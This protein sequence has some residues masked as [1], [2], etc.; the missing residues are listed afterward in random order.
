[1]LLVAE[2]RRWAEKAERSRIRVGLWLG[3]FDVGKAEAMNVLVFNCGS[4]SLKYRLIEMPSERQLAAGEAQRVGPPTALP[5]RVIHKVGGKEK[6]VEVPMPTH[7]DA[8]EQVMA[9]LLETPELKPD[10]VGHRMVHGATT[11]ADSAMVD[12]DVMLALEAIKEMA[13]LHN[14]PAMK[15]VYA[16]LERDPSLPQAV[17]FDTAYHQTIPEHA[18][19]YA[20]PRELA[21]R[22][23]FRKFGF[24][25]TSHQFVAEEAARMLGKPLDRFS[26]VSCHLG[27]G[28]ASLAAIVDGRSVDNTMGYSPLQGLMMSTRCGDLDPGVTLALLEHQGYDAEALKKRLN[29]GSGVLG[30]SGVS[31]EIRDIL[32]RAGEDAWLDQTAQVYLWRIR[33]YLGAYLAVVG[34]ADAVIFTDSIGEVVPAVRWAVCTGM[35][36]FGVEI[37]AGLNA[38]ADAPAK[39]PADIA[40]PGSSV[41]I[42]VIASN[43]ELAIAR[44]T[45]RLVQG[46]TEQIDKGVLA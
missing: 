22:N 32:A 6:I 36:A 7:G 41:R 8:F 26:A 28:G 16:V 4:S 21:A 23:N 44:R 20:L 15:L 38:A 33:K 11:F 10:I 3:S 42:L 35:E 25:G 1:M 14:P 45:W 19:T 43:E 9:L 17:V 34:N 27:S 29:S 13:P 12:A 2:M 24:H 39:L 30:M 18:Y 46:A 5:P 31:A 40:V 37:D